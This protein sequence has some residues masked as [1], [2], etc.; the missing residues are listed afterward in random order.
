[1]F[2]KKGY[3][4][5]SLADLLAATG[6]SK[7]SLYATFGG[8]RELFL[9]AFDSYRGEREREMSEILEGGPARQTIEAFFRIL[10]EGGAD[11]GGDDAPLGFA[12]ISCGIAH[13]VHPNPAALPGRIKHLGDGSRSAALGD[14]A[15]RA[16]FK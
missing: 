14:R 13:E 12:C 1:V 3:E 15:A 16:R 6:L 4:A 2:W 11:P 9:A 5:T 7:S 8:K 10:D